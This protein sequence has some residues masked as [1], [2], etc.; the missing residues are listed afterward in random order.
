M[1]MVLTATTMLLSTAGRSGSVAA[2]PSPVGSWQVTYGAPALAKIEA[3][4][5]DECVMTAASPVAVVSAKCQLP[6]GTTIARVVKSGTPIRANTG[7]GI[8]EIARSSKT[9]R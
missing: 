9:P 1:G 4:G 5:P 6:I 8:P 7:C 3:T 2:P